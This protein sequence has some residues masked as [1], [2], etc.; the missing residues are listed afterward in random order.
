MKPN[1]LSDLANKGPLAGFRI[2]ERWGVV[3]E[4]GYQAVPDILLLKQRELEITSEELNVLLNLTAHWWRPK[5]FVFPGV[6]TI[7]NRMDV[8][9]RTIQRIVGSL[10][11]KGFVRKDRTVDGKIFFDLSPLEEKLKPFA[12]KILAERRRLRLLA[13]LDIP[14]REVIDGKV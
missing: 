13:E 2:A 3:A 6:S 14:R 1:T 8:S 4:P 7:A 12:E 9:K 5:D 11:K 10:T